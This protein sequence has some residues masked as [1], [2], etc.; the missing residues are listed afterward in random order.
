M[1][2]ALDIME[3]LA[4]WATALADAGRPDGEK[5]LL[6]VRNDGVD[7]LP[8]AMNA[9]WN[10]RTAA[11]HQ[12]RDDA[13]RAL[14]AQHFSQ[15][16]GRAAARAVAAVLSRYEAVGWLRDSRTHR[17]PD[18]VAGACYDV[19]DADAHAPGEARIRQILAADCERLA[20]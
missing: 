14:H 12:A 8:A 7:S 13:I 3:Q 4:A 10:W 19:L 17:R 18:G 20:G 9:P 15:L 2:S 16:V 5:A 11:Q 1:P 6:I